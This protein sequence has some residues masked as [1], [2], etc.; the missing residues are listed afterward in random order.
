MQKK[1]ETPY[2]VNTRTLC[3]TSTFQYSESDIWEMLVEMS[4][5]DKDLLDNCYN[6]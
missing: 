5:K 3:R 2:F 4:I 1:N 6:F